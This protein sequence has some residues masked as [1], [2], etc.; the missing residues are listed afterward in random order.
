MW[1]VANPLS[2]DCERER[3]IDILEVFL[4]AAHRLIGHE[5]IYTTT[6]SNKRVC[7]EAG[8]YIHRASVPDMSPRVG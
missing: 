7:N 2:S 3:K 8:L 6:R 5:Y 4:L 1:N